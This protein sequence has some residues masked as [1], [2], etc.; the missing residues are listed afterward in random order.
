MCVGVVCV[1]V[2]CK[3]VVCEG[4]VCGGLVWEGVVWTGV[5]TEVIAGRAGE[6]VGVLEGV[7]CGCVGVVDAWGG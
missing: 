7:V 4:D 1:G 2:V 3:G 6:C 5:E